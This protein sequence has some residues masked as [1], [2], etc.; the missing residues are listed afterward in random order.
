MRDPAFL[1]EMA[2]LKTDVDGPMTGE[3]LE[4][5]VA[6]EAATPPSVI[7]MIADALDRFK[8]Q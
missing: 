4:K 3:E 7:K 8:S 1:K 2:D 6:D 5:F